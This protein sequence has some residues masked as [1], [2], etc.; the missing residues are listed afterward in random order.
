MIFS[1]IRS[2]KLHSYYIK[3]K[4][5]GYVKFVHFVAVCMKSVQIVGWWGH[6]FV[7]NIHKLFWGNTFAHIDLLK[8]IYIKFMLI[9]CNAIYKEI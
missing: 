5:W 7:W 4:F 3:V 9:I 8:Y 1:E 2:R 6:D